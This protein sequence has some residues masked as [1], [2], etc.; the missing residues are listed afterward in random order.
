MTLRV[1][2]SCPFDFWT[3]GPEAQRARLAQIADAG[4]DHIFTADHVS[5]FGGAGMDAM[6]H[7]AALGGMEPRLDLRAGVYLLAL[8]H[9]MVAARK[10]ASLAQAAPGRLTVGV[11]VGGEDRHE[12]E[13]CEIDPRTRGRRTDAS[14]ALVRALLA[15]ET[16]DGDGEFYHFT[17][18]RIRPVPN[19]VVPFLVGG[20]SDAA[21]DRTGRLADGWVATWCSARRFAE[22]VTRIGEQAE[23]AGRDVTWDHTIQTWVGVGATTEEA[24]TH[25][26]SRMQD[27][28]KLDFSRFERYTPVGRG[29]QIAEFLAP[30]VE[31]GATTLSLT[32]CGPDPLAEMEAVAE[33]KRI[34]NG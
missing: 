17:E 15:G 10:I 27:F 1:G 21:L 23:A 25:V 3:L 26:G 14:L 18:G 30:F 34:L 2:I 22:G 28:Y 13:V 4:I 9:P 19:P 12:I 8:R 24:A 33:V 31:A 5:F 32:P 16:V 29:L 6:V 20:R 7:L 11:G